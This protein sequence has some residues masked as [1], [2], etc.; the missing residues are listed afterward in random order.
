MGSGRPDRPRSQSALMPK[1]P[2]AIGGKLGVRQPRPRLQQRRDGRAVDPG[3]PRQRG[4]GDA[5]ARAIA[6]ARR[7]RNRAARSRLSTLS[8][9]C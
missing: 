2:R 6:S 4:L 9:I 3:Q 1:R 5:R 7:V 8:I